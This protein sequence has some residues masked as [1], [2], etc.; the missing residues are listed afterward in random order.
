MCKVECEELDAEC[1]SLNGHVHLLDASWLAINKQFEIS[2][3][4]GGLGC[5]AHE[6]K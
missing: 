5:A 3:G 1:E 2:D 6:E 4:I